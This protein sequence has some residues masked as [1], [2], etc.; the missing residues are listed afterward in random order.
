[1]AK[2]LSEQQKVELRRS[3]LESAVVLI[4]DFEHI[5]EILAKPEPTAGDIRRLTAQ[6]RR[7]LIERDL[8][9]VAAPRLGRIFLQAPDVK[10]IVSS[11]RAAPIPFYSAGGAE[12]FGISVAS[13]LI[14]NA[15]HPRPLPGY[16]PATRILLKV[17]NFLTQAVV[18]FHGEWISRGEIIKY[19]AN[20]A[21]GVHTGTVRE[22][23]EKLIRRV[24]HA[25][26]LEMANGQPHMSANMSV[27]S[28]IDLPANIDRKAIDCALVEVLAA[29]SLMVNSP[30]V[31]ALESVISSET[32]P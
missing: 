14:E 11:N 5:R 23:S 10:P 12:V 19:I 6:L 29:A 25:W 26:K 21:H 31:F 28:S 9:L 17:D 22:S 18:C 4:D 13:V 1:L 20:I 32:N 7:M 2:E 30:D 24:R 27:L 16:D 8:A 3:T 15:G